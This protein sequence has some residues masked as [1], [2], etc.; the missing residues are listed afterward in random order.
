MWRLFKEVWRSLFKNKIVVSGLA[1]LIFLTSGIFTLLNDTYQ[2]MQRQYN[3]YK[4]K[5]DYHDLTVDINL[6]ANGT[7]FN[8]GYYVNGLSQNSARQDYNKP[9]NYIQVD[10]NGQELFNQVY[11]IIDFNSLKDQEFL[12]L[13]I[14]F[15]TPE[16]K[17]S[18][19]NKYI[20][21]YDFL[22]LYANYNPEKSNL[23]DQPLL[24]LYFED[25]L[26]KIVLKQNYQIDLYTKENG[27]YTNDLISR[28]INKNNSAEFR[29]DKQYKLSDIGFL[30][31]INDRE[32][33]INQV[34]E[35]FVDVTTNDF[36]A[37]FDR[38]KAR[39]WEK[40][41]RLVLKV[42]SQNVARALGFVPA[43][44][45]S[46]YKRRLN[47]EF[48]S[49]L[50]S[51]LQIDDLATLINKKLKMR[52]SYES[53]IPNSE[54]TVTNKKKF[55]FLKDKDYSIPTEWTGIQ[56]N[57]TFFTRKNYHLTYDEF[58]KNDWTGTYLTFIESL[59]EKN[60]LTP[61][62]VDFSLWEKSLKSFVLRYDAEGNLLPSEHLSEGND[63]IVSNGSITLTEATTLKLKLA[64]S[65][66]QEIS[67]AIFKN[68]DLIV[69]F[70]NN[71][72]T[73]TSIQNYYSLEQPKTIAQLETNKDN[74]TFSEFKDIT[75]KQ[76][77]E[78]R[79]K[80]IKDGALRIT[81]QNI[82]NKVLERVGDPKNIGIRQT[83]TIDSFN[84][85]EKY[86][87]HLVNTGDTEGKVLE[88]PIEINKLV[89]EDAANIKLDGSQFQDSS[90]FKSKQIPPFVAKVLIYQANY[91]VSPDPRYINPDIEYNNIIFNNYLSKE[92]STLRN[93]KIY[94]LSKYGYDLAP[95][96]ANL[97]VTWNAGKLILLHP[98]YSI[99]QANKI[100]YWENVHLEKY[101]NGTMD[102]EQFYEL[103]SA[104]NNLLTI[105]AQINPD[106]WVAK[107]SDFS[108]Q[109]YVPFGYRGPNTEIELEARLFNTL[110]K[111]I[112]SVEKSL[113]STDLI[114]DSFI[115]KEQVYSLS[116]AFEISIE[117]NNFAKV[118]SSAQINFNILPKMILD[119]IY[120]LAHDPNGD[121]V[122]KILITILNRIK[123][124]I[125]AQNP[126][127]RKEYLTN[128]IQKI[129]NFVSTAFGSSFTF[130]LP[131][132]N[133]VDLSKDPIVVIDNLIKII[134]S[135]NFQQF[136]EY[137]NDFFINL[138]NKYFDIDG[139]K[140]E[141]EYV[142]KHPDEIFYQRKIS[143][144]EIALWLLKS[145]DWEHARDGLLSLIDNLNIELISNFDSPDNP[146]SQFFNLLGDGLKTLLNQMD[147][148]KNNSKFR[149]HNLINGIKDLIKGFEL[150]TFV[151][152]LDSKIKVTKF[153][154]VETTYDLEFKTNVSKTKYYSAGYLNS[155]IWLQSFLQSLFAQPGSNKRIKEILIQMFNISSKGSTIKIDENTYITIPV[156]DPDKLD[157]FDFLPLFQSKPSVNNSAEPSGPPTLNDQSDFVKL[158]YVLEFVKTKQEIVWDELKMIEKQLLGTFFGWSGQDKNGNKV[159]YNQ[160]DISQKV[161]EWTEILNLIKLDTNNTKLKSNLSISNL[162]KYFD[163]TNDAQSSSLFF[164]LAKRI[165]GIFD[166][167]NSD[168]EYAY[169][170]PAFNLFKPLWEVL[171]VEG[172]SL[173]AKKVFLNQLLALANRQNVIEMFN[174]FDLFQPAS[175]NIAG[176]QK[177]KFGVSRSLANPQKM[178]DL[179]FAKNENN[180][181]EFSGLNYLANNN[182]QFKQYL[183]EHELELTK[184][185]SYIA[186]SD[187]FFNYGEITQIGS[188]KLGYKNLLSVVLNNLINGFL[189]NEYVN[190]NFK[191]LNWIFKKNYNTISLSSIGVSDVLLNPLLRAKNPQLLI[192]LLADT[193]SIGEEANSNSNIAYF[194]NQKL[195]DFETLFNN[196]KW[197][198][199]FVDTLLKLNLTPSIPNPIVGRDY[200][201]QVAIDNDYILTLQKLISENKEKYSPFD[202]NLIDTIIKMMDS[203]TNVTYTSSL[204]QFNKPE[205]YLAKANFAWLQKNNKKIYNGKIPANPV[206]IMSLISKLPNDYKINISGSDYIII[207]DDITFDYLYPVIDE[208]NIQVNTKNQAIVYVN[209]AGFD[210]IR[211]SFRGNLV[212]E[213][214]TVKAP[215]KYT[216]KQIKDLQKDLEE[217]VQ[218]SIVSSVNLQRVYLTNEIDP[219]NPERSLRITTTNGIIRA[220]KL[221][222]LVFL[223]ILVALVGI[224]IIFI[225]K[226]Y[227]ANKNKV[228]GILVAQGYTP[229]QIALSLT[230]FAFFTIF[231][232]GTLGF[233][234]GFMFHGL[235][236]RLLQSYWTIPITTLDLSLTSLLI[237][238]LTPLG[239]MCLLIIIIA[240][241]SLKF[242]A[243]D[244]MS[245]IVELNTSE[246]NAK[247]QKWSKKKNIKTKFSLSLLFNSFGKLMSFAISVIL[248]SITT[249]FAFGTFGVFDRSINWT[250]GN[251]HYNYKYDLSSPTREGGAL[252]PYNLSSTDLANG[253]YVP[254]GVG[255]EMNMYQSNYFGTGY[256]PAINVYNANGNPGQFT[257]HLITQFSVN[258]KINKGVSIDPWSI[259]YNSLP[260]T[261]KSRIT[262][263][264]DKVGFA[265]ES[266]QV[267][268]VY[269]EKRDV[270]GNLV[271]TNEIDGAKTKQ[272][273]D[274]F[275]HYV[276]NEQNVVD[277]K[278]YFYKWNNLSNKFDREEITTDNHRAEYRQFLANGY[279]ALN[280]ENQR[281]EELRAQAKTDEEKA[282]L[283]PIYDFF[284]SFNSI[285]F[286]PKEDEGFTY[287]QTS[288]KDTNIKLYGYQDNSKFVEV[289]NLKGDNLISL[290]N[291]KFKEQ[292]EDVTKEI[293]VVINN[294]SRSLFNLKEGSIFK[295]SVQNHIDRYKE[296][297]NAIMGLD[298]NLYQK[299]YKFKVVGI[300]N[301]Y[302][303]NEFI[304]PK[305]AADKIVGLDSLTSNPKYP[306]FNGILSKSTEPKQLIWT[307]GLYSN[308]GYS[309]SGDSFN[310]DKL[311]ENE[312]NDL[313]DGIFGSSAFVENLA[314]GVM[315]KDGYTPEQIIKFLNPNFD[316]NTYSSTA[317]KQEY[318]TA[319]RNAA[320]NI[321]KFANIY[322]DS[323]YTALAFTLDAKEI[324]VGFTKT[325]SSTVQI[326]ITII[327]ILSFLVSIIIL[328]IISTILINENEKN[329]AIW[330]ILGYNNREKIRMFFGI[331][332]P[333]ILTALAIAIPLGIGFMLIFGGFLTST[334]AIAVPLNIT[335]LTVL[336]TVLVVFLIFTLTSILIW[337]SINKIKAID[338]LKGK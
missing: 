2:S 160:E 136:T 95:N 96:F 142:E 243:I 149:F 105:K 116:R 137:T 60:R 190:Q 265:L 180:E 217:I 320:I 16:E 77:N 337:R 52:F 104:S 331:Y 198:Y 248:A 275:F 185:F 129:D 169:V 244:L 20:K 151:R 321:Q 178:R 37:T 230:T 135:I 224:S 15:K 171:E 3:S 14:F 311:E 40:E 58:H 226:R 307:T 194:I 146:L 276:P 34:P 170:G 59:K 294:V 112:D 202:I 22:N 156:A 127:Q 19:A 153:D 147:A 200:T 132:K 268:L 152:I 318:Q 115:T 284:V 208:N 333:F 335:L 155:T 122:A 314:P 78:E 74:L 289:V 271:K 82:Y 85:N 124:K 86:V 250:Y 290:I 81:K 182:P 67:D 326:I 253:L 239:A 336:L 195:V 297:V 28:T 233:L 174:S 189:T 291:Q 215:L 36:L 46:Y 148:Y 256:S 221:V 23:N 280:L 72:Q 175:L 286:D 43:E 31:S 64:P 66:Y 106:G 313:F 75:N 228:I 143:Y 29:F 1:I 274:W 181:Y 5:S 278:F 191:V 47:D 10:E 145:I 306:V 93:K 293:P 223:I 210:R 272:N 38:L 249:V 218:K 168:D 179:F 158:E 56:E 172:A 338:L 236:I 68:P 83:I 71:G 166:Q 120:E 241:H 99:A 90:I 262:L 292:G 183:Q 139:N 12:N 6:P 62:I 209:Q 298:S 110:K 163:T 109:V 57:Y 325:I 173:E 26:R 102:I 17:Q 285:Y 283:A 282:K 45:N 227:I 70:K 130:G 18:Y 260:D 235:S 21:T 55:T 7:A 44:N 13:S 281:K 176:Y 315:E 252:N 303:N 251:R 273:R 237:N 63:S 205:S 302:I 301:T 162:F 211:Q 84:D 121:Q 196:E 167:Y 89:N 27:T 204:L 140:V 33:F 79:F 118:F 42:S 308:S 144:H 207:G 177:T 9:L 165:I 123:E 222:A 329:I 161:R 187:A 186:S 24:Q 125:L 188:Y 53:I 225:I 11:K 126:S 157:Y 300:I 4:K 266:T 269:Q 324:E 73:K 76:I 61:E 50:I 88:I 51:I 101:P 238:I 295:A 164:S 264:R 113:L 80:I 234:T 330:S 69:D 32:I 197:S 319:K 279:A 296:K 201:F 245:G 246:F 277:G 312:R 203:I 49:G 65:K 111:G 242:K 305:K 114:K 134:N 138:Y 141:E 213:Y 39:N 216:N 128:E 287:V 35:L 131:W 270:N 229:L 288:L 299:E 263:V 199:E 159:V 220:V 193:N 108:N 97:G 54:I 316:L 231:L 25:S 334:A 212:K 8:N 327:S 247:I 103:I 310:A 304:I 119:G 154:L 100:Q 255:E 232:G 317:L 219:L 48:S 309:P 94:K 117:K 133:L 41:N 107:S 92:T 322:S 206:D 328:I 261:Q 91:N 184:L 332:I 259:V 214:L 254:I 98:V 150:D 240:L 87:F 192:W 30:G 267:G 258:I 257:G 323:V